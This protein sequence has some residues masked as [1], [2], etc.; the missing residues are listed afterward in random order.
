MKSLWV[1]FRSPGAETLQSAGH[2]NF[3]PLPPFT[4]H[5]QRGAINRAGSMSVWNA[6][7]IYR[8]THRA[9]KYCWASAGCHSRKLSH[10]A[11]FKAEHTPQALWK[12]A[13]DWL[14]SESHEL[15]HA[16][17]CLYSYLDKQRQ[18]TSG[19]M[20]TQTHAT[21]HTELDT[22]WTGRGPNSLI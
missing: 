2:S 11:W 19:H 9:S 10:L 16:G 7:A 20:Q 22:Q 21:A 1:C 18:Q 8:H 12:G 6:L 4:N 14:A 13:Y 15:T 3:S 5:S 17:M